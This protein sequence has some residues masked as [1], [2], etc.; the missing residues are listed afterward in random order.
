MFVETF[1]GEIR[2]AFENVD[3]HG[4]PGEDVPLLRVPVELVV[5]A[6][7]V[8]AT[9]AWEREMSVWFERFPRDVF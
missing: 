5:V 6:D 4:A 1:E 3:D 2:V 7:Y 9:P 8:D